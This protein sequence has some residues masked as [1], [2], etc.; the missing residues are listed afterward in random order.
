MII[1]PAIDIR[2]GRCVRLLQ[3]RFDRETVYGDDPAAVARRWQEQGASYLHVVDLDGAREGRPCNTAAVRAILAA[4]TVP[5]QLGGGLRRAADVAAA[6]AMGVSRAILGSAAAADPALVQALC[7]QYGE[8]I[9][10]ALDARGGRVAVDGWEAD[11]G[12]DAVG[13]AGELVAAGVRCFIYTDI[14]RDGTLAG[15]NVDATRSLAAAVGVPVIASGGVR[16]LADVRRLA[17]AG[18]AGA[19]IGRALYTGAVDLA[20]ALK[21]AREAD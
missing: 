6:L 17:R 14:G 20:Q 11:S 15:V 5:V 13:L 9:A 4:V 7:A 18:L 3:G 8:K 12:R 19:I 16:D 2:Q 1:Y 21:A 10:V